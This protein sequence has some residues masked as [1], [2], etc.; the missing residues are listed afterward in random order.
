M[1]LILFL[2]VLFWNFTGLVLKYC[3]T[4]YFHDLL[5]LDEMKE[6]NEISHQKIKY[7]SK[8]VGEFSASILLCFASGLVSL[9]SALCC[10]DSQQGFTFHLLLIWLT[11][12]Y[13][14]KE[15]KSWWKN[16]TEGR[17]QNNGAN[18]FKQLCPFHSRCPDIDLHLW[19]LGGRS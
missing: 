7:R 10:L 6:A 17:E 15:K 13:S 1:K 9:S 18:A 2:S 3:F 19:P 8:C 14:G 5:L 11:L 4:V 12:G 16:D